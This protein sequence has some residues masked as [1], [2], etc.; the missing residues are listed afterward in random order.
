M[1]S[2]TAAYLYLTKNKFMKF[3]CFSILSE[4]KKSIGKITTEVGPADGRLI[5]GPTLY[6]PRGADAQG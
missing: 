4:T 1:L 2:R 6:H 5:D 3:N